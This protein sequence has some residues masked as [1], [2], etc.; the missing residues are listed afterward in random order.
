MDNKSEKIKTPGSRGGEDMNK[1]ETKEHYSLWWNV[2]YTG[3]VSMSQNKV[4]SLT[5]LG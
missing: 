4:S 2:W 1:A 5:F 3:V